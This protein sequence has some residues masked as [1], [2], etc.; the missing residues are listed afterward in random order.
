M[1]VG[2]Y[3]YMEASG[4]VLGETTILKSPDFAADQSQCLELYYYMYG[5]DMG[6]FEVQTL[7]PSDT[8]GTTVRRLD[9]DQG[10]AWRQLLV[11]IPVCLLIING[12]FLNSY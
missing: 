2:I 6:S 4:H 3:A 11:S 10:Q 9:G 12:I 1:F 7:K 5:S 8:N